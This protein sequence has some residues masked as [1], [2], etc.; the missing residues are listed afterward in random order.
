MDTSERANKTKNAQMGAERC[1]ARLEDAHGCGHVGRI[2]QL[3]ICFV[4][5]KMAEKS[6]RS[7]RSA[8]NTTHV[9]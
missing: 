1:A 2:L 3:R 8:L 4:P 7:R 5:N 9:Q 6:T